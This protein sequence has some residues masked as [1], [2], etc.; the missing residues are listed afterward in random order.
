[1]W[2]T[3]YDPNGVWPI[4]EVVLEARARIGDRTDLAW[5]SLNPAIPIDGRVRSGALLG[6]RH[7]G[8]SVWSKPERWPLHVYVCVTNDDA[9][10]GSADLTREQITIARWGL[11]HESSERAAIDEY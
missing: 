9:D 6:A 7:V 4:T 3:S 5:V 11:L 10:D 2:L 1:V 8:D